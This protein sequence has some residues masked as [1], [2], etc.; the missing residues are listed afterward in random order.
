MRTRRASTAS[1]GETGGRA[2]P[3]QRASSDSPA[4]LIVG[5]WVCFGSISGRSGTYTYG[6]DGVVTLVTNDGLRGGGRYG[7]A[8]RSV[9]YSMSSGSFTYQIE[10][11]DAGRM[12]LNIGVAGQ[13]LACERR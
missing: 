6:A 4:S 10:H 11:L 12:V 7:V 8:G 2:A 5:T 9:R 1:S 13:R 3:V